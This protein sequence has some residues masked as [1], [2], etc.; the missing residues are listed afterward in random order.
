MADE[1]TNPNTTTTPDIPAEQTPEQECRATGGTWNRETLS[2]DYPTGLDP[3]KSPMTPEERQRK[4]DL[5]EQAKATSGDTG[6]Q[7]GSTTKDG[8]Q[9]VLPKREA[10]EQFAEQN[11]EREAEDVK[12][13]ILDTIAGDVG[14]FGLQKAGEEVESPEGFGST[15]D[16]KEVIGFQ[17]Y[18]FTDEFGKEQTIK[19]PIT[20]EDQLETADAQL[21][22]ISLGSLGSLGKGWKVGENIITNP[23]A[24]VKA[25]NSAKNSAEV[26][27]L[28]T[29]IRDYAIGGFATLK[30][31]EGIAQYFTGRKIDEQQQALNTLGQMATTI[32]GQAT[33]GTGD[34]QK[35]L[36]ELRFIKSEVLRLE[37]AIKSGT[38]ANAKIKFDG[39]IYDINADM[40]DQ[41]A[42]I[43]EQITIIQSFAVAQAFP[44]LTEMETQKMLRQLE[45]AG[46]VEPIDLKS[47]RRVTE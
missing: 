16:G 22:L 2:C 40:S 12:T 4:L 32:G 14:E 33:E 38:I 23:T 45:E 26:I 3:S 18:T 47:S 5:I 27:P 8:K 29:K 7:V 20:R 41:L 21:E 34:Y 30:G 31:V 15:A 37:Q 42:T 10:R 9:F 19:A 43:D 28:A 39:K 24:V 13:G 44:E 36:Q 46:F 6:R 35:G 11:L 1:T 25:G 17:D